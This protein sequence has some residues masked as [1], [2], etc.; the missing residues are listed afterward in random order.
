MK[1]LFITLSFAVAAL[2]VTAVP[3]KRD[4]WQTLRL[5]DGTEIYARLSGDEHLHFWQASDGG[6]YIVGDDG[7]ATAAPMEQMRTHAMERRRSNPAARRLRQPH[8]VSMGEK[9]S[10]TGQKKGIVILMQFTDTK[11][12]TAN[13]KAK[14]ND[15]LNK[16]NYVEGSFKGSVADYFKA[17]SN[18]LF[19]LTFDVA[20]PYTASNKA[21]YY[22]SNDS[23]G[24]DKNADALVVEAVN[25]ANAE[26][27]FSDYDWDGDGEVD[28][29]F[30][31]Y[32]GK[33]EAD[34]GASTTIWPHMYWL[35]I[36]GKSLTLD[37]V[38]IDT[39]ACANELT[40]SGALS[41]IGCFCHEFSHCLGYPD[42]Y[43]ISYSGWF[44]MSEFDIMDMGSYNGNAYQPAGYTAYEKLMAGWMEPTALDSVDVSVEA[45]AATSEH[46]GAYIMY[47]DAHHDEFYM[48]ENRQKS[49]WDASL[50][51][52]GLMITHVDFD[53]A[54]WEDNTPNTK[55]T[56]TDVYYYGYTKTNDHQRCTIFHAD[57]DDDSKH[58]NSYIGYYTT[59]T[60]T[61]DLYPYGKRD[62][63]TA[64]STPAASLYNKNSLGSKVMQGALLNIKQ[65]TDG[66]MSFTYRAPTAAAPDDPDDPDDP[67]SPVVAKGDTLFHETFDKCAGTGGNDGKW[68]T[69]IAGSSSK[70]A[71]DNDG[72]KYEAE[73][74]GYKCARFGNATSGAFSCVAK[75]RPRRRHVPEQ[76]MKEVY[77]CQHSPSTRCSRRSTNRSM[78]PRACSL[79]TTAVSPS[80]RP[81]SSAAAS[82]RSAPT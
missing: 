58:W 23:Y 77:K 55:V 9:T 14:Y 71:F 45:L 41:G 57:N 4:L 56:A 73:Y 70:L 65:N 5:A 49:N 39:Y 75:A 80:R 30:I 37:G 40:S 42:F 46:G 36:T 11:F 48:I 7:T 35:N 67:E 18:G 66:T 20:G 6:R 1:K 32:A 43:D 28:Q 24:N 59:T 51:A 12:K 2:S 52:K 79:S 72:W 47:N 34:G 44:G 15:V 21:S 16:E 54:I 3:A 10:Y 29:V 53:K 62:S 60:L 74:G 17:Q 26:V 25:A 31:V 64:T 8:K 19:N 27:D 78:L 68:G 61:T 22:G 76:C 63:L 81:R 50:P 33:G 38:K 13:N 69:S 82:A